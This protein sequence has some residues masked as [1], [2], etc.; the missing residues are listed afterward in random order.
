MPVSQ[1]LI[2]KS[3]ENWESYKT[4]AM[5][6]RNNAAANRLYFSIFQLVYA[7]ML[8]N[9]TK[10][11]YRDDQK[12]GPDSDKKHART[13]HYVYDRYK[14]LGGS[15]QKLQSLRV[16]AD[17]FHNAPPVAKEELCKC[18]N[19]WV[20]RRDKFVESLKSCVERIII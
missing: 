18:Y 20:S 11:G 19:F 8:C 2:D 10:E 13:L 14:E 6:N 3:E 15:Y 12:I 7:E 9:A 1:I 16:R 4:L 17:Y 5:I